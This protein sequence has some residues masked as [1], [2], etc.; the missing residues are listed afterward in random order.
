MAMRGVPL[1]FEAPVDVRIGDFEITNLRVYAVYGAKEV[2]EV[3][4]GGEFEIHAEYNIENLNPGTGLAAAWTTTMTVWDVTHA[5]A[6]GADS[7][8]MHSGAG[9]LT[10]HDA[11]NVEMP[12]EPT[13]FRVKIFAN[14]KA[15][16]GAPPT[17]EW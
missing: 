4:P 6:I 17:A 3:P 7:F 8:G 9:L 5:R 10:A 14:Q 2:T 12:S 16:A 13:T 11:V 1:S 15:N